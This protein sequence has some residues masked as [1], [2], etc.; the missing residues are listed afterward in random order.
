LHD[1]FASQPHLH[2]GNVACARRKAPLVPST[3]RIAALQLSAHNREHF[4]RALGPLLDRVAAAAAGSDL[5]VLPEGTFPAYVLGD[6]RLENAAPQAAIDRIRDIA[7]AAAC[8]VVIGAVTL[9]DRA[10]RNSAIVID[11]DGSV[12]GRADKVFLWHFDRKWFAPGT[13]L[14]PVDTSIGKLGVMICADGR[15]PGLARALVDAGAEL[16]VMPTAW[17]TSGRDP[18]ALENVQA[19]LLARVR[20]Y[21]NGIP[22]V[23]AN[24][25]GIE[26]GMVAYCGKSQIVD[27][28][29]EVVA[30][31][32]ES[33]EATI[34]A[35]VTI[36]RAAPFRTPE[37][38]P[39]QRLTPG[40]RIFRV[41]ITPHELPADITRRLVI[42]DDDVALAPKSPD[43]LATLDRLVPTISLDEKAVLDP[44]ALIPYRMAGY[45][46]AVI[47]ADA[48]GAWLERVARARALELR[49]YVIVLE[50][51][52]RAYALD[53]DGAVVAGT[54][55]DFRIASFTFDLRKTEQTVVAPGTDVAAG[56]ER[57][58]SL[59]RMEQ[60]R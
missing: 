3:R 30:I 35:D 51:G 56:I 2:I 23:A 18:R 5:L 17:V 54:Y 42:L 28:T 38:H 47:E 26:D 16:L 1:L 33:E 37:G 36:G 12:A 15:M 50:R 55:D 25:C 29:G 53:P 41:A 39:T 24:K 13:A 31:A 6:A 10:L 22:F 60:P 45:R 48:P 43:A 58:A 20:A 57:I 9:V 14:T 7:R 34:A 4:D 27:R 40:E 44:G 8:V 49:M 11:R 59:T 52:R 19:D 21:E 32:P 46:C